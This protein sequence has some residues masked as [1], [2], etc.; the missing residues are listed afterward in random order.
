MPACD[1]WGYGAWGDG[2]W[3]D[4]CAV[5]PGHGRVSA[6]GSARSVLSGEVS[7]APIL[8]SD[9]NASNVLTAEVNA[10]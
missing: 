5:P 1:E 4:F 10:T 8:A 9:P 2:E 6:F 7:Y 3:G